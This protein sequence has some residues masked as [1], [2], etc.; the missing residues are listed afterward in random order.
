MS[1]AS[2]RCNRH[3]RDCRHEAA[4]TEDLRCR[5]RF[6]IDQ[7][8]RHEQT[9]ASID[10]AVERCGN[11]ADRLPSLSPWRGT[12]RGIA[13]A[14]LDRPTRVGLRPPRVAGRLL[15]PQHEPDDQAWFMARMRIGF[16]TT[17]AITAAMML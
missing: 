5:Y 15:C 11:E 16:S 13:A 6:L 17:R 10:R 2:S 14:C 12:F 9:P 1:G 3:F 8:F 4:I 7:R